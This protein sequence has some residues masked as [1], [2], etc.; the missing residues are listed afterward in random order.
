MN[1]RTRRSSAPKGSA[2]KS[3]ARRTAKRRA[4]RKV[5]SR[6]IALLAGVLAFATVAAVLFGLWFWG[7]DRG[8]GDGTGAYVRVVIELGDAES[9]GEQLESRGLVSDLDAFRWYQTVF[10]PDAVFE[11]GPHWLPTRSSPR[12]LV[13]LL[14]RHRSRTV[15]KV[16]VPEGF[17]VFQL[18]QR[19]EQQGIC[20]AEDFRAAAF[21]ASAAQIDVGAQSYEGYLYPATYDLRLNTSAVE[22]RRRLVEEAHARYRAVF[23]AEAERARRYQGELGFNEHDLVTLASVVQKET[24]RSEEMGLVASVFK[25]RLASETFRPKGMLQSDPTAGY[26]CKLPDA[27]P[28]CS[29]FSGPITPA[30]LRDERNRYNTY[31]HAGLPPGPVCNPGTEVLRAVLLA[32]ATEYLYFFAAQG[33]RHVFSRSYDEHRAAIAGGN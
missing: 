18:A 5:M 14:A 22:I 33:G 32:P 21:D 1:R 13:Q 31:R 19:L 3:E 6:R 8:G 27:P 16:L 29:G 26:G 15:Q 7:K 30:L 10:L 24:S 9:V 11:L 20:A 28:S 25:N 17:D 23:T 2:P 12:E 4:S